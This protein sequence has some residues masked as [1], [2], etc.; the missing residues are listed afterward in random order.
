MTEYKVIDNFLEKKDL[1]NLKTIVM[2]EEF[3]WTYNKIL[4]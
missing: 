2:G 3:E 4:N 1:E